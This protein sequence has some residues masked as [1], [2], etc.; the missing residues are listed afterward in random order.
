MQ[1]VSIS[2]EQKEER[3]EFFME[4]LKCANDGEAARYAL[5]MIGIWTEKNANWQS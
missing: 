2:S 5:R 4:C 1:P 3:T